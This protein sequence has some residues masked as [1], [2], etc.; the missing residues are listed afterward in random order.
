MR[1][2]YAVESETQLRKILYE[3]PLAIYISSTL[4]NNKNLGV[5]VAALQLV[6]I[7]LE[8]IPHLYVPLLEAEGIL[9]FKF[10]C[11]SFQLG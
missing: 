11:T 1:M 7:L 3:V 4:S 5:L 8:K 9:F 6:H 2:I 10:F